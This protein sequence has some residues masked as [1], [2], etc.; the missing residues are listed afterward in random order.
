MHFKEIGNY[1]KNMIPCFI[2]SQEKEGK[3]IGGNNEL[4][5]LKYGSKIQKHFHG[6]C[7]IVQEHPL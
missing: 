7:S 1:L 2:I 4:M 5:Y 6:N 3:N